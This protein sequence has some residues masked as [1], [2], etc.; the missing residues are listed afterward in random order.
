LAAGCR[1][2]EVEP[3]GLTMGRGPSASTAGK[4]GGSGRFIAHRQGIVLDTKTN[5]MWAAKDNGRA[6]DWQSARSYCENYRG[7]G[8]YRLENADAG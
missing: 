1:H 7:G 4:A 3:R 2:V 8:V 5:L 6:V